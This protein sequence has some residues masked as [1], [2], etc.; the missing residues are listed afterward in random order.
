[1]HIIDD[2]T[3]LKTL[4]NLEFKKDHRNHG[5]KVLA[6]P[7]QH[8]DDGT[9]DQLIEGFMIDDDLTGMIADCC[10]GDKVKVI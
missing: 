1:L 6:V 2:N 7:Q 5:W 8:M 10:K 9:D 4:S 3:L